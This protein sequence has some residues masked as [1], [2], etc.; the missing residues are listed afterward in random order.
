MADSQKI[1]FVDATF[2]KASRLRTWLGCRDHNPGDRPRTSASGPASRL[3][4]QSLVERLRRGFSFL[5]RREMAAAAAELRTL[6]STVTKS[7]EEAH[8]KAVAEGQTESTT[9]VSMD[10]M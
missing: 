5:S 10:V 7:E 3:G 8:A 9:K 6:A 2:I 4:G 1:G